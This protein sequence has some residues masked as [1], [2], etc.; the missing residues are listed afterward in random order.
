M[1][2]HKMNVKSISFRN[3]MSIEINF[4]RFGKIYNQVAKWI[5]YK[6]VQKQL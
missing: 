3:S 6:D 4:I 2:I 5:R 1:Q